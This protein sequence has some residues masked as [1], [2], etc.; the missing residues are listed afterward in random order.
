MRTFDLPK[1]LPYNGD[2][3]NIMNQDFIYTTRWTL[4]QSI[5]PIDHIIF[6][7]NNELSVTDHGNES[8]GKWYQTADNQFTL[9]VHSHPFKYTLIFADPNLLV[10]QSIENQ[11]CL[12]LTATSTQKKLYLNT[13]NGVM[14]Y[15]F[16][17]SQHTTVLPIG[18][19]A[20]FNEDQH[21]NEIQYENTDTENV[22]EALD[23]EYDDEFSEYGDL[24]K[25]EI[26]YDYLQSQ[27]E[28]Q[29]EEDYYL[30]Q[31]QDED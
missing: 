11:K 9:L 15:I 12:I 18:L 8:L 24:T 23:E 7:G 19:S 25:E 4:F 21:H 31:M 17:G 5:Y 2:M 29:D 30:E 13:M 1:Q 28:E 22:D 16:T 10:F 3:S 6:Y 20:L 26:I 14:N 27:Q